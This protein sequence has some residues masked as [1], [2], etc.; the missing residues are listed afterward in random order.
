[1][2]RPTHRTEEKFTHADG[3][4][5]FA[6]WYENLI[7]CD[8]AEELM[9]IQSRFCYNLDP[10]QL[11]SDS[12]MSEAGDSEED[13]ID[14]DVLVEAKFQLGFMKPLI[15]RLVVGV[16]ER[17]QALACCHQ[18][19][20][21]VRGTAA[22]ISMFRKQMMEK[23][24]GDY[25]MRSRRIRERWDVEFKKTSLDTTTRPAPDHLVERNG[26]CIDER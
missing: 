17:F 14:E 1:M 8:G 10:D 15:E 19:R 24:D 9:K 20:A 12:E 3:T 25:C 23:E 26:I 18:M 21:I 11:G 2:G 13:D 22:T 16:K 5:I 4:T 6:E 7:Y